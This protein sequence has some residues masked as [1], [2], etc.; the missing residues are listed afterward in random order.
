MTAD[1]LLQ[2]GIAACKAGLKAD[3]RGLFKQALDVDPGS[4][5][6]WLWLG[7]AVETDQ[8]RRQCLEVALAI[9]PAN[10]AARQGL[11]LLRLGQSPA[12][13][14]SG[15]TPAR[16]SALRLAGQAQEGQPAQRKAGMIKPGPRGTR[17]VPPLPRSEPTLEP[18][19]RL[20]PFELGPLQPVTSGQR[21]EIV[22]EPVTPQG[23]PEVSSDEPVVILHEPSTRYEAS[24]RKDRR[25]TPLLFWALVLGLGLTLVG[26]VAAF[27]FRVLGP[28]LELG[29]ASPADPPDAITSVVFENIAAHNAEDVDRYIATMHT[30]SPNYSELSQALQGM[31]S[32]F[33]LQS[34]LSG[35]ELLEVS[36][37]EA[38]VSFVLVTRKIQGPEFRDNR[39][40]GVYILQKQDGAWRLRDQE[41]DTVEYLD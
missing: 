1:D 18:S 17:P 19:A 25:S 23:R 26:V 39:L 4:E 3:A 20:T 41:I 28:G 27:L 9:N 12:A 22:L 29:G 37:Q 5:Q 32:T 34:T 36:A 2:R 14:V 33:D 16:R 11:E 31:Y 30:Q 7:G 8:E 40:E 15:K 35:V 24:T 6:A 13:Q 21:T 38:R 10:E